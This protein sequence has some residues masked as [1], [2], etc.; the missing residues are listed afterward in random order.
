MSLPVSMLS[1]IRP[2]NEVGE[3]DQTDEDKQD[4][5]N[6]LNDSVASHSSSSSDESS[7]DEVALPSSSAAGILQ[8]R[9][10]RSSFI[11]SDEVDLRYNPNES[12]NLRNLSDRCSA[13]HYYNNTADEQ[14]FLTESFLP[15]SGMIMTSNIIFW[16]RQ[17]VSAFVRSTWFRLFGF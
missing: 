6:P 12:Y 8:E 5:N 11:P 13:Q 9:R 3:D 17:S 16:L 4:N 2:A 10:Q 15:F 7:G 1:P 14:T